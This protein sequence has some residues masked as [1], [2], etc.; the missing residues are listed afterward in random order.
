MSGPVKSRDLGRH[1]S[2]VAGL[3]GPGRGPN[4][5]DDDAP[6]VPHESHDL[7]LFDRYAECSECGARDHWPGIESECTRVKPGKGAPVTIE[8][9]IH[10]FLADLDAFYDWWK[11]KNLGDRPTVADWRAEFFEWQRSGGGRL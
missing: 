6:R 8:S 7:V 2:F 5:Y 3:D 1:V 11:A 4:E 9:A 10:I